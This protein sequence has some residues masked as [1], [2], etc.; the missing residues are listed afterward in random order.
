MKG[1]SGARQPRSGDRRK[2]GA[3][4][5]GYRSIAVASSIDIMS[6][7]LQVGLLL[8]F[9]CSAILPPRSFD[10]SGHFPAMPGSGFAFA[11]SIFTPPRLPL[12]GGVRMAQWSLLILATIVPSGR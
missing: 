1:L 2:S 10:Y 4:R 12:R 5:C 8:H 11:L 9:S 6:I 3:D 7:T